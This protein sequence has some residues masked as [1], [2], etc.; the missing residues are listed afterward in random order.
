MRP[1]RLDVLFFC[2]WACT[3]FFFGLFHPLFS[4]PVFLCAVSTDTTLVVDVVW[5]ADFLLEF[6]LLRKLK[7]MYLSW[8]IA[9]WAEFRRTFTDRQ[10]N[11]GGR[12]PSILATLQLNP[13]GTRLRSA[14]RAGRHG[15]DMFTFVWRLFPSDRVWSRRV[16]RV[17]A[18]PAAIRKLEQRM[19]ATVVAFAITGNARSRAQ[20]NMQDGLT[21][22]AMASHMGPT[23]MGIL[24]SAGLLASKTRGYAII[25]QLA[26]ATQ[27]DVQVQR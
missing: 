13:D 4:L 27:R 19:F 10:L 21:A 3:W 9:L 12:R 14:R 22:V 1:V 7:Q 17:P 25:K 24:H 11:T 5:L 8:P 15:R 2:A 6:D 23:M 20:R 26:A 18:D 16:A